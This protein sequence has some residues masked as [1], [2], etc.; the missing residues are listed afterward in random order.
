[1]L[2]VHTVHELP[3]RFLAIRPMGGL[4]TRLQ[5]I[6]AYSV[7]AQFVG[8]PLWVYWCNS[9][10][11]EDIGYYELFENVPDGVQLIDRETFQ[12][13][14]VHSQALERL[15]P[16]I[17]K[18][19]DA[20]EFRIE[21]LYRRRAFRR[22][23]AECFYDFFDIDRR[24]ANRFIPGYQSL[25]NNILA[26]IRPCKALCSAIRH[27]VQAWEGAHTVG[28]HIRRDDF[29]R[30]RYMPDEYFHRFA[31][32]AIDAGSQ[33]FLATDSRTACEAFKER[34]GDRLNCFPWQRNAHWKNRVKGS[35]KAAVVDLFT[36][37]FCDE[38]HGTRGSLFSR[39]A[40]L[41]IPREHL[42]QYGSE[43]VDEDDHLQ[44]S[45]IDDER[46][47]PVL[48]DEST[49]AVGGN[50]GSVQIAKDEVVN[51]DAYQ[52]GRDHASKMQ[53][54]LMQNQEKQEQLSQRHKSSDLKPLGMHARYKK[55]LSSKK[56]GGVRENDNNVKDDDDNLIPSQPDDAAFAMMSEVSSPSAMSRKNAA[57]ERR[58][59]R[60][61][62]ERE[63][64]QERERDMA[65]KKKL[66]EN[67]RGKS[68]EL[69]RHRKTASTGQIYDSDSDDN[70]IRV[71][72]RKHRS[73]NKAK[74][75]SS[76]RRT[77]III[78]DDSSSD[79]E[80]A[81]GAAAGEAAAV[82]EVAA[83][84]E[85]VGEAVGEVAVADEVVGEAAA[86]TDEMDWNAVKQ[87]ARMHVRRG[88][89]SG[90]DA[91]FVRQTNKF[92]FAAVEQEDGEVIEARIAKHCVERG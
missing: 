80:T 87:G 8:V 73:Q 83:A 78:Y 71:V 26:Q 41:R 54:E 65:R 88:K 81:T 12:L 62:R 84:G 13:A 85:A 28:L 67:A 90:R 82:G 64:K 75:Q 70:S 35:Q 5:A 19:P 11:F 86:V 1:M 51:V 60:L 48:T 50:T 23:S 14:R 6:C 56:K 52:R 91:T 47:A 55:I 42:S 68:K 32:K 17:R 36:L 33:L 3:A 40:G 29:T 89:Y 21:W 69:S 10:G 18:Q 4:G 77:K 24:Q 30:R 34:Y 63:Q 59:R 57:E 79:D 38:V 9:V 37:R 27:Q 76:R 72:H 22:I 7:Y 49:P 45:T 16:F 2:S 61:A 58:A 39:V 31:Q 74:K 66:Q 44:Y 43:F 53:R 92:A 46:I 20:L 15:I 25:Q